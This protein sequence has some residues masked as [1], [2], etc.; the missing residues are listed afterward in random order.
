MLA[1][2]SSGTVVSRIIKMIKIDCVFLYAG[3]VDV[4][5]SS[6]YLPIENLINLIAWDR[7]L[8]SILKTIAQ[9]IHSLSN[10]ES[11]CSKSKT[12]FVRVVANIE[13]YN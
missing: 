4:Y 3:V 6:S 12:V 8:F 2:R 10:V 5:F 9:T 1:A 7:C 13:I 11:I